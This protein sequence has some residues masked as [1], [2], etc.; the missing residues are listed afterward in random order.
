VPTTFGIPPQHFESLAQTIEAAVR[1]SAG[2]SA[3]LEPIP[4]Q[5]DAI[6]TMHRL[7]TEGASLRV[8]AEEVRQQHGFVV[9]HLAV[10][11]ALHRPTE[12]LLVLP[13]QEAAA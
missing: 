8:I 9:S 7:A 11:T 6:L 4:E 2:R 12:E 3:R 13:Q 1:E 10:R 5:Q